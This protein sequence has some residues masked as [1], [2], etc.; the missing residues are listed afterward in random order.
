MPTWPVG[1]PTVPLRDSY[2][3]TVQQGSA[4]R[5]DMDEGPPKQ[6]N[7]F[8]ASTK[9]YQATFDMNGSQRATF[10]TFYYD[11]LGHGALT[12]DGLPEPVTG[13]TVNHRF[14]VKMPPEERATGH[15]SYD[16]VC[17]LEVMP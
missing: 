14:N 1:L 5:S 13:A 7:R 11:A 8:T 2:R 15:D 17:N 10:W 3:K 6:R 16:V 4:I 9:P 12:F